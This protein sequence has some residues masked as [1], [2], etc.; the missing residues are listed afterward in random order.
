MKF[1]YV[2]DR[3]ELLDGA[4]R[5]RLLRHCN[6]EL[7]TSNEDN[8]VATSTLSV[9]QLE[10][11]VFMELIAC[12]LHFPNGVQFIK[13]ETI[14]LVAEMTRFR[15]LKFNIAAISGQYGRDPWF[16]NTEASCSN[17]ADIS[18]IL[19]RDQYREDDSDD[20]NYGY[21]DVDED[22]EFDSP[23]SVRI[24]ADRLP[25]LPDNMRLD[26]RLDTV[27]IGIGAKSSAPFSI[28]WWIYQGTWIREIIGRL[29]SMKQ[30]EHLVPKYGLVLLF[31]P[32]DGYMMDSYHD[33][34]GNTAFVS[35]AQFHPLTGDLWIGSHGNHNIG[36]K[37]SKDNASYKAQHELK[38]TSS[39][40]TIS[41]DR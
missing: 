28:L 2:C 30:V 12:G 23:W 15:I 18:D 34:T 7:M 9:L 6:R 14:L 36:V 5:G 11:Q 4:P 16:L 35:E 13:N 25:G 17:S 26:K 37:P 21:D 38:T 3:I 10:S 32:N 27:L 22:N 20:S 40:T 8:Y 19:R 39:S 29:I 24:F 41:N 1:V 31:N 33:S